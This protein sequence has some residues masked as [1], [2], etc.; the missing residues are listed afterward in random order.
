MRQQVQPVPSSE[1]QH[2]RET[3]LQILLPLI[4]GLSLIIAATVIVILFRQAAQVSLVADTML[5]VFMLCPL[6]IC[7]LPITIGLII[8]AVAMNKVHDQTRKPLRRLQLAS[9][10]MAD[11]THKTTDTIN[12]KT[13][14]ASARMGGVYRLLDVFNRTPSRKKRGEE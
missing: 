8:A 9:R 11:R 3:R 12:Q 2:R 6:M 1:Q 14:N 5:I 7:L 4:L 13:I 10:E